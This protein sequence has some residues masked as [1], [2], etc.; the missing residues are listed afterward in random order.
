MPKEA[1]PGRI[2]LLLTLFLCTINT[3]NSVVNTTPSSGGNTSALIVWI[4]SCLAF[5]IVAIA[6]Y[7]WILSHRKY[8]NLAKIIVESSNQDSCIKPNELKPQPDEHKSDM[9]KRLDKFMV[10]INP[11]IFVVFSIV[12]WTLNDNRY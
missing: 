1:V 8:L 2:A 5:I 12:Y 6:E 4:M 11:P 10:L 3:L 9:P 7:A